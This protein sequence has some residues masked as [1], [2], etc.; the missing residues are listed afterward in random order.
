MSSLPLLAGSI[1]CRSS[2]QKRPRGQVEKPQ[3]SLVATC[4]IN[5]APLRHLDFR[6][7]KLCTHS[8][9]EKPDL[10]KHCARGGTRIAFRPLQALGTGENTRN[11]ARQRYGRVRR[12]KVWTLSTHLFSF[13]GK[14]G[15]LNRRLSYPRTPYARCPRRKIPCSMVP[16]SLMALFLAEARDRTSSESTEID[17]STS[18]GATLL[19]LSGTAIGLSKATTS[20]T[21][22]LHA[23]S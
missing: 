12:Q 14:D 22:R 18:P 11:P 16:P 23:N 13:E 6:N 1:S 21:T 3:H 15:D 17:L 5:V 8:V 2:A 19:V 20:R 4:D 7:V 9:A 10:Q